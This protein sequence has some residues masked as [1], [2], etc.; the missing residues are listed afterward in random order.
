MRKLI[1]TTVF[2]VALP[3]TVYAQSG[4]V[5]KSW[6]GPSCDKFTI[7][8]DAT[9]YALSSMNVADQALWA[10]VLQVELLS[11]L[12]VPTILN[13]VLDGSN[14]TCNDGDGLFPHPSVLTT[15]P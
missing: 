5:T 7:S 14:V 10:K 9:T 8:G 1:L 3:A 12:G 4:S 11:K 2:A 6:P 15:T 13:V